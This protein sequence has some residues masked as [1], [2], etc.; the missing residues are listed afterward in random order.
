MAWLTVVSADVAA[1]A[2]EGGSDICES[3]P[4][5]DANELATRGREGF[6]STPHAEAC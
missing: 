1:C 2:A 5:S 4:V 6:L 3:A